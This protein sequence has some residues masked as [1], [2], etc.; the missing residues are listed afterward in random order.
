MHGDD[1]AWYRVP[2]NRLLAAQYLLLYEMSLPFGLDLRSQLSVDRS[3]TKIV[4][5]LNEISSVAMRDFKIQSEA[6]LRNNAPESMHAEGGSAA[7][8]FAFLSL[9]L[10]SGMLIGTGL[11]FVLISAVLMIALQDIRL[12]LISLIPNMFP[13]AV[14][15]GIWGLTVGQIGM[16]ASVI[17][18]ATLGLV[19][20][21]TVHLLNAY[22]HARAKK[23]FS[24]PES[25][26]YALVHVGKAVWSTTIVLAGGFLVMAFSEFKPNQQLG[27]LVAMTISIAI[28]LDFFLLPAVLLHLDKDS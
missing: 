9:R 11:A 5:I 25:V 1:P 24:P 21:D 8:M 2:D 7:V 12:G 14:T 18:A 10:I 19:V 6:W 17:T 22:A 26:R 15:L 4:I 27:T 3:A 13:A 28:V 20:D 23:K 16:I